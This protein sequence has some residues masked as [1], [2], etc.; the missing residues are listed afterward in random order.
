VHQLDKQKDLMVIM[1]HRLHINLQFLE[2]L[3]LFIS[4]Q[5]S[6]I[7]KSCH[8]WPFTGITKGSTERNARLWNT[9]D[10]TAEVACSRNVL[11][12]KYKSE[13]L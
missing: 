4:V 10:T 11:E 5:Y 7:T 8:L 1:L 2:S 9:S 12:T 3:Y 13:F 6:K